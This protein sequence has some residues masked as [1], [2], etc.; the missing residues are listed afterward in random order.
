MLLFC[1]KIKIKINSFKKLVLN[2]YNFITIFLVTTA[3][4][5]DPFN[6]VNGSE[7]NL[8]FGTKRD[9]KDSLFL[10]LFIHMFVHMFI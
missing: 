9:D 5:K 1:E 7:D 6:D 10:I 3:R 4:E 8:I 2:T